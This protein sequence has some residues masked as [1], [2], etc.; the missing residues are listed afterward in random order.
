VRFGTSWTNVDSQWNPVQSNSLIFLLWKRNNS[1]VVLQTWSWRGKP[2]ASAP[3]GL[4][5]MNAGR[6]KFIFRA[7]LLY[8]L[9]SKCRGDWDPGR[10]SVRVLAKRVPLRDAKFRS[11]AGETLLF[12]E[13]ASVQRY[14]LHKYP[15]KWINLNLSLVY[16]LILGT[17][18]KF[19][20]KIHFLAVGVCFPQPCSSAGL[21]FVAS[22]SRLQNKQWLGT[23]SFPQLSNKKRHEIVVNWIPLRICVRSTNT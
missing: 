2:A 16:I 4:R 13:V 18:C 10:C 6:Q 3:A 20:R 17:C 12:L 9:I 21:R 14:T 8:V 7:N 1:S 11:S 23:V 19:V 15:K 5:K 22:R